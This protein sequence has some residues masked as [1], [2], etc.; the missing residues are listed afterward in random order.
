MK[1]RTKRR[2]VRTIAT[3]AAVGVVAGST[4]FWK[5]QRPSQATSAGS[6]IAINDAV[7]AC[8]AKIGPELHGQIDRW[9]L[10]DQDS[11]Q[12]GI[13]LTFVADLDGKTVVYKC[14]AAPSGLTVAVQ[15]SQ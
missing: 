5:W 3:F 11:G 13:T 14:D 15:A 4:A 12:Q 9:Q 10:I 6:R 1:R 7:T 8:Q 2:I